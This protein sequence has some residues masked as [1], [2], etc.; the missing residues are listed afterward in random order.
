MWIMRVRDVNLLALT[1]EFPNARPCRCGVWRRRRTCRTLKVL[2]GFQNLPA[3]VVSST[4]TRLAE[5]LYLFAQAFRA[6]A[7]KKALPVFLRAIKLVVHISA[8]CK[9]MGQFMRNGLIDISRILIIATDSDI[10]QSPRIRHNSLRVAFGRA[11]L[12]SEVQLTA[13]IA[14][15]PIPIIN[16][17]LPRRVKDV[18]IRDRLIALALR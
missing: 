15:L 12:A 8:V 17:I 1:H 2:P 7:V 13:L 10:V 18:E 9:E 11:A 16:L 3:L 6:V 5:S 14:G 4:R